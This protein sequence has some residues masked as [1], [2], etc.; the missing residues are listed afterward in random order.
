[1]GLK[2]KDA[3]HKLKG[4]NLHLKIDDLKKIFKQA[5]SNKVDLDIEFD[6]G[7][8]VGDGIFKMVVHYLMVHSDGDGEEKGELMIE[9]KHVGDLWTTI[10]KTTAVPFGAKP[11]IPAAISNMEVKLESDRKTKFNAKYVNPTKNRD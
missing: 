5:H 8:T 1:M 9:R 3:A 4:G 6:G 11:I 7:A 10:L 2:Y